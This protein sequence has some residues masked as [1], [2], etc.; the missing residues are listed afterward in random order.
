MKKSTLYATVKVLPGNKIEIETPNLLVGETVEVIILVP[1][2]TSDTS[3]IEQKSL[4]LKQR[5]AFLKLP[6]DERR[7]I[8]ESQAETMLAHYQEDSEWQELMAGDIL[9]Y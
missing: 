9:D 1:E 5:L 6:I 8:L 2:V 3:A 7:H 4:S